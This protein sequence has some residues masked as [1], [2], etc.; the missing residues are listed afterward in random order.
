MASLFIDISL[1]NSKL[2]NY[3]NSFLAATVLCVSQHIM[4]GKC[5]N[6]TI[7]SEYLIYLSGIK[8]ENISGMTTRL[9][10]ILKNIIQEVANGSENVFFGK[11]FT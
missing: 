1:S 9:C 4:N 5:L 11:C 8:W 2:A 10:R 6:E 7:W 3:P